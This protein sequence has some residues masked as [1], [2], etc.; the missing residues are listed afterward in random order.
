LI[1]KL[2]VSGTDRTAALRS[3]RKALNEYQVVGPST[4]LEFLE[5]LAA[6]EAFI[7]GEVETGFIAVRLRLLTS[8]TTI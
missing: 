1:S 8:S 5:R 3:L 2:I 4:N 7:A 6:S